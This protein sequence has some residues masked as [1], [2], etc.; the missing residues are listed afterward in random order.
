MSTIFHVV[1][2][3]NLYQV[4]NK[5]N[6]FLLQKLAVKF[7]VRNEADKNLSSVKTIH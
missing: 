5:I 2:L 4:C 3:K 1:V 6:M 7:T